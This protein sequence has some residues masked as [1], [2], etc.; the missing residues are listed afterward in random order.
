MFSTIKSATAKPDHIV[1]ITW[2]DGGRSLVDF[3]PT[4]KKGGVFACLEDA[5]FFVNGLEVGGDGDWM[6]WPD[7]LDFSADSLWRRS[8]PDEDVPEISAGG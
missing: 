5:D 8:H 3:A 4:I 1:E 6:G 2:T 7:D